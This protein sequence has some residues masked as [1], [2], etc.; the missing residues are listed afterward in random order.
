MPF[1]DT[2]ILTSNTFGQWLGVANRVTDFLKVNTMLIN[3][4]V[5][6]NMTLVGT[7]QVSGKTLLSNGAVGTPSYSFIGQTNLGWYSPFTGYLGTAIVGKN[8][9]LWGDGAQYMA[10]TAAL[11]WSTTN[12]T[13]GSTDIRLRR[14]ASKTLS[15]D[16]SAG[17][18]AT[19]LMGNLTTTGP[20]AQIVLNNPAADGGVTG[21]AYFTFQTAGVNRWFAG[22]SAA[23][24]TGNFDIYDGIDSYNVLSIA[25]GS[26]LTSLFKGLI[27]TG[28]VAS[29]GG[30][31]MNDKIVA[32][33]YVSAPSGMYPGGATFAHFKS[34]A[35]GQVNFLNNADTIGVGFDF[36]TDGTLKI[37]T[38]AQNADAALTASNITLS[39]DVILG[40][41]RFAYWSGR[42]VTSSPAD[43]Q[44]NITN[45]AVTAGVGFD[46]TVD[47]TLTIRNRAQNAAGALSCG[48]ITSTS[49]ISAPAGGFIGFATRSY[50]NCTADGKMS[51]AN[52]AGTA[53][54]GFDFTTDGVLKIRDKA[55]ASDAPVAASFH[56]TSASSILAISANTIT[57]T[58]SVHHVSTTNVLATITVPATFVTPGRVTFIPDA[59]F[60][61][62]TSGNI[63][64]AGTAVVNKAL[65]MTWDGTKW[66]P[67]Y[68]S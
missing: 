44:F 21:Q 17:G 59:I 8:E 43:G 53:G 63:S 14:S 64:I 28:N 15:L 56:L 4:S 34:L 20:G 24:S 6:A 41:A 47:N 9:F 46:V 61:W 11:Y 27:V 30:A 38:R 39:G 48:A 13:N 33:T 18:V 29:T 49:N 52:N 31:F 60:T 16:D 25:K 62:N 26:G 35:D 42:A 65:T 36:L 5:T 23:G 32:S 45:A 66:S 55:Q 58:G 3:E 37:R 57:P 1:T 12:A 54:I 51:V 7:L 2:T 40:A 50:F 22:M 10:N 19:F 68:L 67:S